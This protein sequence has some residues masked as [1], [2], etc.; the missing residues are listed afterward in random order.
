[1]TLSV[2]LN[3]EHGKAKVKHSYIRHFRAEVHR[4]VYTDHR[5]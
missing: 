5:L 3:V 2:Q 4:F 1:M